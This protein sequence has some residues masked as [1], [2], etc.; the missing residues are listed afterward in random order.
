MTFIMHIFSLNIVT[1]R[2]TK[3][4]PLLVLTLL[5]SLC[6]PV[7]G[8]TAQDSLTVKDLKQ[9]AEHAYID[10]RYEEAVAAN[11]EIAEKHHESAARRYA[12]QLLGTLYEDNL[13]DIKKAIK[14]D[15]EF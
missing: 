12:V 11:L 14:W 13:V 6:L 1:M 3:F 7:A 2:R 4:M 15:R 5:G 10:R 9:K 8:F